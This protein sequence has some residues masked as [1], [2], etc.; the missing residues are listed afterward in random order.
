MSVL[1]KMEALFWVIFDDIESGIP[2][3]L[4]Q[5]GFDDVKSDIAALETENASLKERFR[6]I[7]V[8]ERLPEDGQD[9]FSFYSGRISLTTYE[10]EAWW[11]D[12]N[13]A[14][15]E[16]RGFRAD[17]DFLYAEGRDFPTHWMEL[18]PPPEVKE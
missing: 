18:P 16:C 3:N 12:D 7:P 5:V 6:W 11:L 2:S 9:V 14:S 4:L 10:E 1:S 17:N 15:V 13:D 8:S